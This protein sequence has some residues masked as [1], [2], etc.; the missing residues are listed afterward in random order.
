ME[1]VHGWRRLEAQVYAGA[2]A[3]SQ[4]F[5][6]CE[7]DSN[8]S[9]ASSAHPAAMVMMIDYEDRL[10]CSSSPSKRVRSAPRRH[11]RDGAPALA[12]QSVAGRAAW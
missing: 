11:S 7:S 3:Q 5:E 10:R 2:V 12:N 1:Q 9:S 4:R 6:G 8:D